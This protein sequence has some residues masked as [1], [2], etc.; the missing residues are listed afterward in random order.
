MCIR[1]SLPALLEDRPDARVREARA[2]DRVRTLE[3]VRGSGLEDPPEGSRWTLVGDGEAVAAVRV[4]G[5]EAYLHSVAVRGPVRSK[6]L[7]TL[8]A[9]AALRAARS[10]GAADAYLVTEDGTSFFR[11]LGFSPIPRERLPGG[12]GEL[13][14]GCAAGATAMHRPLT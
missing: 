14:T 11:R 8:V 2:E 7:G 13:T 6:G 3:L 10:A 12:I 9:A 1:D 5:R 4:A